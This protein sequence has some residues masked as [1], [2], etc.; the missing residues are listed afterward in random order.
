[1]KFRSYNEEMFIAQSLLASQFNNI[2]IDKRYRDHSPVGDGKSVIKGTFAIPCLFGARDTILK[3]LE[4]ESGT[5]KLPLIILTSTNIRTDPSRNADINI[6]YLYQIDGKYDINK[7]RGI[8]VNIEYNMT[9]VSRYREDLEQIITNFVPFYRPDTYMK[10]KHPKNPQQ[11][12]ESQIIWSQAFNIDDV[13]ETKTSSQ[14]RHRATTQFT[15]KTWIFPGT[16]KFGENTS[17]A[18]GEGII[19]VINYYSDNFENYPLEGNLGFRQNKFWVVQQDMEI[20]EMRQNIINGLVTDP[21]NCDDLFPNYTW[22][23]TG[24][25]K[26]DGST[27]I[28]VTNLP[29]GTVITKLV[30]L[31]IS[32]NNNSTGVTDVFDF[33]NKLNETKSIT[34]SSS[35]TYKNNT[36]NMINIVSQGNIKIT[37]YFQY[38][39][40]QS[41]VGMIIDGG[42]L[43]Q[44][45]YQ[46][47]FSNVFYQNPPISKITGSVKPLT[48]ITFNNNTTLLSNLKTLFE[49]QKDNISF[50]QYPEF[51]Q[52]ITDGKFD[53]QL[54]NLGFDYTGIQNFKIFNKVKIDEQYICLLNSYY[55][56][57]FSQVQLNNDNS[58][59]E[60]EGIVLNPS[61]QS[62]IAVTIGNQNIGVNSVFAI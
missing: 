33:D 35:I 51:Y 49:Q 55:F 10:W 37:S 46:Q 42:T 47:N 22:D 50:K 28:S 6:D 9:I 38:D 14:I 27:N 12:I 43:G 41:N 62:P 57:V 34:T 56:F 3:E 24:F 7:R 21:E 8:P 44:C 4:N 1:M 30:N 53:K 13:T 26:F 16:D 5:I 23:N 19:E 11:I 29:T 45:I 20:E 17:G 48:K 54:T 31:G 18:N 39:K 52:L 61:L 59:P 25:N 32:S 60:I 40:Q 2:I 58:E 15:F 36:F